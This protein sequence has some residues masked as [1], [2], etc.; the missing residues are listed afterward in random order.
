VFIY[1]KEY[2]SR[3]FCGPNYTAMISEGGKLYTWGNGSFGNLG[4]DN[5]DNLQVPTMVNFLRDKF[6]NM[7]SC[8]AKHMLALSS[9]SLV[10]S[11]GTGEN[12]RLGL[13]DMVGRNI[14][15]LLDSFINKEI[16]FIECG[17]S[18]SMA[19][20]STGDAFSWGCGSYYRLGHGD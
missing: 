2:A 5:N 18:H 6:I 19:L 3:V 11:W 16:K 17:E 10:Y 9:E 12:G 14:P 15:T 8:G 7:A 20:S 4:H 1:T 13:G